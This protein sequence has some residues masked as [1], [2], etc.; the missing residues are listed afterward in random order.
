MKFTKNQFVDWLSHEV[1]KSIRDDVGS[2]LK[3]FYKS[4]SGFFAV[5]RMLFPEI[6]G[7]GA[8]LRGNKTDYGTAE[9]IVFYLREVM[10]KIDKRYAEYAVF[11]TYIFRH[12]LL[13]QHS[14]KKFKYG[15]GNYGWEFSINSGNFIGEV[16]R[17]HHL[18][19]KNKILRIDMNLFYED[20]VSSIEIVTSMLKNDEAIFR[21]I[22]SAYC[23]QQRSLTKRGIIRKG[24]HFI[25]KK[26]FSFLTL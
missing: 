16:A 2:A 25:D 22:H 26:D 1:K 23:W 15:K 11:I 4:G 21:K 9:N 17:R 24:K 13:H 6:D 20:V 12:G 7:L 8:L 19:W 10:S 14:P 5:P 18:I 3:A